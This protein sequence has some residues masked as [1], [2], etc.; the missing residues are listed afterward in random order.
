MMKFKFLNFVKFRENFA[1]K[2]SL[3]NFSESYIPIYFI[4]WVSRP[5]ADGP[6]CVAWRYQH[7]SVWVAYRWLCM[8]C[9][10]VGRGALG[11][12]HRGPGLGST[13]PC[14][15]IAIPRPVGSGCPS[16]HRC[17]ALRHA[18]SVRSH[19]RFGAA[20]DARGVTGSAS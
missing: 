15:R 12:S 4:V 11:P 5:S 3:E 19:C 14:E 8:S 16:D 7:Q 20:D 6:G 9:L 13:S 17:R 1:L 2:I 10:L 18:R